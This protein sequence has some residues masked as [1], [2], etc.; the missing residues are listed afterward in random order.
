MHPPTSTA[1]TGLAPPPANVSM[2]PAHSGLRPPSR[3]ATTARARYQ[4]DGSTGLSG[5]KL[6]VALYQ[7]LLRDL[8]GAETAIEAR[9][10]ESAHHQLVHAQD[11]LDSLD[12]ALDH[13][14]WDQA[15][16]FAQLYAHLGNELVRAN[17]TKKA[18]I[19]RR[20]RA[21]VEPMAATWQDALDITGA[22]SSA[23]PVG[24]LV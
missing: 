16:R 19:V 13:E 21:I 7:R 15:P 1:G 23:E 17:V 10:I 5:G 9:Q 11:I 8:T 6:V 2:S 22:T 14:T 4:T 12:D 24:S 18:E 3:R 20:C